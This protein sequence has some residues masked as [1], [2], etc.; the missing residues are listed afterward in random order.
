MVAIIDYL[1]SVDITTERNH[2]NYLLAKKVKLQQSTS[3]PLLEI[4]GINN[5][6]HNFST[7]TKDEK[8]FGTRGRPV[9]SSLLSTLNNQT[10]RAMCLNEMTKIYAGDKG[11]NSNNCNQQYLINL[12][13]SKR[14][15]YN[16]DM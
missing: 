3:I 8:H 11:K 10:K 14:I 16:L 12:N 9:G 6:E 5:I 7:I 1:A 13:Y 15:E 2:L 4:V